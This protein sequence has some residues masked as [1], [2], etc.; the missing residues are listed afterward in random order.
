MQTKTQMNA[1]T[2]TTSIDARSGDLMT[3]P[4]SLLVPSPQRNARRS[5]AGSLEGL[6]ASI[7]AQG[8][9]QNLIV[10]PAESGSKAKGSAKTGA[11]GQGVQRYEV[12]GGGR[13]LRALVE[14]AAER[15]IR[16][17]EPIL[18]R[19]KPT[20]EA[21]EA[22]LAENYHR[23]PM[24]P[25]DEFEAFQRLVQDGASAEEVAQRFGTSPLTVRRR[26]KLA[27]VHPE[28]RQLYRDDGIDMEQLMALALSDDPEQ[29]LA[30]WNAAPAWCRDAR[31]LRQMFVSEEVDA[32]TDAMAKFVGIEAYEAAGGSVRRDLFS[33]DGDGYLQDSALL[34]KLAEARLD[35]VADEVR[36]E[37]WSWVEVALWSSMLEL[38]KF[39]RAPKVTR[40]MTR[41]EAKERKALERRI[42][43]LERELEHAQE[44]ASDADVDDATGDNGTSADEA[45]RLEQECEDMQA[46]LRVLVEGLSSYDETGMAR[47]GAIV[48][49]GR[50][51][52]VQIHRGLVRPADRGTG[53]ASGH[54]DEGGE[55]TGAVSNTRAKP[56]HSAALMR[57]L[58]AHPR[59]RRAPP[60]WIAR[61]SRSRRC[62]IAS[63]SG[64]CWTSTVVGGRRYGCPARR[65]RKG[66]PRKPAARW[67]KRVRPV[68]C[69]R[70]GSAGAN[71]FPAI[72][73][74]CCPGLPRWP[75][76]R[77]WSC[78]RCA[79]H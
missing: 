59:W 26:L 67:P 68:C 57:E 52:A 74:G 72:P 29:Q 77:R 65:P 70:R 41:K 76:V 48:C 11:K 9:L 15:R 43:E 60:C 33:E 36:A 40:G 1:Q 14:L 75:R 3:I 10:C 6:K 30:V 8:V 54:E 31:S 22:S 78:W 44:A 55:G 66:S 24:H 79:S 2:V 12:V 4:L 53:P 34:D 37:G 5:S 58:T 47:S 64:C 21:A 18:C 7:D 56:K 49:V 42:D 63:C 13:R 23:A 20:R 19:V 62:C 25:A 35:V 39:G 32:S 46:Q 45:D 50:D 69:P 38:Y 73:T 16:K 17:D 51:G 61:M 27:D 71:A 28:L